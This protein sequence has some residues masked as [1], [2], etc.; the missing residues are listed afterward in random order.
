MSYKLLKWILPDR[1]LLA[2]DLR[3]RLTV[4]RQWSGAIVIDDSGGK[5]I[6]VD[7]S[8]PGKQKPGLCREKSGRSRDA[9]RRRDSPTP[10]VEGD[11][12]TVRIILPTE[13]LSGNEFFLSRLQRPSQMRGEN[14]GVA[15]RERQDRR[16]GVLFWSRV[17]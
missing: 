8:V 15:P 3:T 10:K 11:K 2:A 5:K 16:K 6:E 1:R 9:D 14:E 12:L 17:K 4:R 13:K 7:R